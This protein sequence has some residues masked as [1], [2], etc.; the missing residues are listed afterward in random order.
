[1]VKNKSTVFGIIAIIIGA[2]GLGLGAFS[3]VNFQIVEG[4]QGSP[5]LDGVDGGDGVD[6]VDGGDG[7][8]GKDG[9]N[10]TLDNLVAIWESMHGGQAAIY[11]IGFDDIKLNKSEYFSLSVS[12]TSLNLTKP[13]WYRF[14][15]RV[16]WNNLIGG[17]VYYLEIQKNGVLLETLDRA[18]GLDSYHLITTVVY[19][20]SDGNDIFRFRCW[21]SS[22]PFGIHSDQG[23]NQFVIEYVGEY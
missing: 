6:G 21:S 7:N 11:F 3:I 10:G 17:N 22:P 14:T 13:G 23:Y 16:L 1:M 4:P 2:S 8:D 5:G 12:N 18:V 15:L 9:I 19:I 20:Y